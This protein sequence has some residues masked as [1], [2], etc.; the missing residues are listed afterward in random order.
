MHH[1]EL[2]P[3]VRIVLRIRVPAL[4]TLQQTC[5]SAAVA[6]EEAGFRVGIGVRDWAYRLRF[7]VA[8]LQFRVE[9]FRT[10]VRGLRG[11]FNCTGSRTRD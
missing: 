5:K 7:R 8:G 1:L 11:A 6:G 9:G 4:P 10:T 2:A 3:V